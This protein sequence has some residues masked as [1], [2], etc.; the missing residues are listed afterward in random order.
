VKPSRLDR[1]AGRR[2]ATLLAERL[3]AP[4]LVVVAADGFSVPRAG[5]TTVGPPG[6]GA[7]VEPGADGGLPFPAGEFAAVVDASRPGSAGAPAP[8][9]LARVCRAGGVVAAVAAGGTATGGRSVGDLTAALAAAG[10]ALEETVAFDLLGPGSPWRPALGE[11]AAE[12]LAELEALLRFRS[13]RRAVRL[14]EAEVVAALPPAETG[15]ALVVA[16]RGGSGRAARPPVD[17]AARLAAPA[18]AARLL[19][20]VQEDAVVRLA[21]LVDAEVVSAR[22]L[23]FDLARYLSAASLGPGASARARSAARRR[24]R[25]WYPGLDARRFVEA[26]S[27]RIA[28]GA[29]A[30]LG[31]VDPE[32][33]APAMA[34]HVVETTS[35]ALDRHLGA[36]WPAR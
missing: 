35:A 12:V 15:S 36:T 20:L 4:A 7:A 31:P 17:L 13:V 23:G 14:L 29:I 28:A 26:A 3:A 34:Y 9:E 16:R 5:A 22:G 10:C 19:R 24:A 11:R 8:A 6:S 18:L 32:G 27:Y 30:A 2:A 21:A 25:V 33:L 1:L